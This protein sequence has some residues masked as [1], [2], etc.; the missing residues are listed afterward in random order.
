[1][2]P[3]NDI[4]AVG[5]RGFREP[6]LGEAERRCHGAWGILGGPR[7]FFGHKPTIPKVRFTAYPAREFDSAPLSTASSR[8]ILVRDREF[9]FPA[10]M[11]TL[12]CLFKGPGEHPQDVQHRS[13]RG[14]REGSIGRRDRVGAASPGTQALF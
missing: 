5:Q 2:M 12:Q 13:S 10:C 8:P 7:V 4:K 3:Y 9:L 1:L 11:G 6:E 14:R